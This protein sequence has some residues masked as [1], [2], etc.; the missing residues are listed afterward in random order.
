MN[1]YPKVLNI[2]ELRKS[3]AGARLMIDEEEE[4]RIQ[5]VEDKKARGKGA[6][7]KAKSKG[8]WIRS[9][10]IMDEANMY[11]LQ[12]TV[13][14]QVASGDYYRHTFYTLL[15]NSHDFYLHFGSALRT[16]SYPQ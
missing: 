10:V 9:S 12:V 11:C 15:H 7:T 13:G 1:Y 4:E 8:E 2:Q 5:D 3:A 14:V 6:P 16:E